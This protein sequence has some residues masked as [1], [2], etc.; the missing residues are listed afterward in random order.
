MVNRLKRA[1][2]IAVVGL[3]M[4]SPVLAQDK[5]DAAFVKKA[6]QGNLAEVQMGQLAQQKGASD[7]VRSFGQMLENDHAQNNQQATALARSMNVTPPSAPNAEQKRTYDRLSKLSGAQFDRE[8]A[9]SMVADHKKDIREFQSEAKSKNS[10]VANYANATLPDLQKHLQAA[11]GL[12][13]TAQAPRGS[14]PSTL[15]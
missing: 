8:F 7:N 1:A 3:L 13:Q 5:G 9:R 10:Q 12:S 14:A 2:F 11:E 6:I 15:H 4:A